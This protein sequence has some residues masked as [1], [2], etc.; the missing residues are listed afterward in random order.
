MPSLDADVV[1]ARAMA[2]LVTLMP[3]LERH[4]GHDGVAILHKGKRLEYE[5]EA[6]YR[7]W[8]FVHDMVPSVTSSEGVVLR[9]ARIERRVK[10]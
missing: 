6:A 7:E 9:L 3:H 1:T 5:L 4:L 8:A 2:P 10:E